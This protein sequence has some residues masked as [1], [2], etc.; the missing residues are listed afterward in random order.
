LLSICFNKRAGII[1]SLSILL[2]QA[3]PFPA[4]AEKAPVFQRFEKGRFVRTGEWKAVPDAAKPRRILDFDRFSRKRSGREMLRAGSGTSAV[5]GVIRVAVIRIAFDTNRE[6]TL[7][8][9]KTEGDFDLTPGGA[10]LVDPTPHDKVFF[11]AQMRGLNNYIGFQ[12]CGKLEV[13]WDILPPGENDAFKLSDIDDYGP[14]SG[15]AGWTTPLLA[16]FLR[17]AVTAADEGLASLGYPVRLSDYDAIILVHAGADLQGDVNADSPNDLPSFFALLGDGDRIPIEGGTKIITEVSVVPETATQDGQFGGH[18]SVLAHEFGHVLGLPDLYDVY[19]GMPIVG[20]WDQMDSGSQVGVWLIDGEDEIF[21]TGIQPS[22][23]GAWSRYMLGWAEVDTVRTFDN[24]I[25]LSAVEK[26]PAKIV[27]VDIASDEFFLVENRAGEIDDIYTQPVWDPV[28]GVIIGW[29]NCLNCDGPEPEEY[30]WELVNA[31]DILLPTEYDYAS[32]DGGPGVLV[33]HVD[34]SFIADRFYENLVNSRWPFG[35]SLVEASGGV[36]LGNPYSSLRLG[37]YD[38]A[39]FEG[40]A[41]ELSDSTFPSSWSNWGVPSGVRVEN[42]SVRDT[43]MTFGAG[44]RDIRAAAAFTPGSRVADYGALDLPGL[45]GTILIDEGGYAR[46]TGLVAP[47][48][49]VASPAVTPMALAMNF[50]VPSGDDAVI[51]GD[52]E[53]RIHAIRV[54]SWESCGGSWPYDP[55]AKLVSCPA[56]F[57]TGDDVHIVAAYDDG[58][59][60]AISP[61]GTAEVLP[62]FLADGS[63]FIGNLVIASSQDGP[64]TGIFALSAADGA[65]QAVLERF[66]IEGGAVAHDLGYGVEIPLAAPKIEGRIAL[67]GGDLDPLTPGIE[68]CII[69]MDSGTIIFCNGDGVISTRELGAPVAFAPSLQDMNGDTYTDLVSTDGTVIN[70]IGTSGANITGWPRNIKELFVLP[71]PVRISAPLTTAVSPS[72]AWVT[73]GTDAGLLFILDGG[74]ELVPGYPKRIASSF[75]QAVTIS[76][77]GGLPVYSYVDAIYN[78]GINPFYD[79]R[80]VSGSVKW[81]LGPFEGMDEEASW[82]TIWGDAA[83][84]AFA[85]ASPGFESL[86]ADWRLAGD[87]LVIYPNPSRDGEVGVHFNAPASGDA[88]VGIMDLAGELVYEDRKALSGGEDEF[89]VSLQGA[90]SGIY[91]CRLVIRSGGETVEARGKFA[92]VR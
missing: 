85:P 80:P 91:L 18:A 51:V 89:R 26:S 49:H 6:K 12:S 65:Q 15:S 76:A 25:S 38:D 3:G 42:V 77:P 68:I 41:V 30:E 35:V 78:E 4:S 23:F 83:R 1:L 36:D 73:A 88:W 87:D 64:A 33:W 21:A 58:A 66:L 75:D 90:A 43:L 50:D 2:L 7:T 40:N 9:I 24:T 52:A 54:G 81:R 63:R 56:V 86:V 57:D 27:R 72:G 39:F 59:L 19:Y 69:A 82:T 31:Y 45:L 28:S 44:V 46:V 16:A 84:T 62:Y 60:R 14:G 92:V 74:G 37:W 34:E 32:S 17:A 53:G 48:F 71:A 8:S 67:L 11:D 70:V 47:V 79:F 10:S 13:E 55:G 61:S 5:D 29:G 22:G 20:V